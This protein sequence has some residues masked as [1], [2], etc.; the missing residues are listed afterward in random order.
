MTISEQ[1]L[2]L[3]KRYEGCVLKA[4]RCPAGVLTIGYGHTGGVRD[5]QVITRQEADEYLKRDVKVAETCISTA[6]Q[7][8]L[9]QNQF[10]AL[11]SFIF[12]VGCGNFLRSTLL[13]KIKVNPSDPAIRAEFAKWV[14]AKNVVLPGL[15]KRRK[16]EAELYFR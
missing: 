4:Y 5:G 10:D 9:S 11:C 3:I 14:H 8:R 6:I 1:G 7:D 16:E 15:V 2:N 13:K 12:N